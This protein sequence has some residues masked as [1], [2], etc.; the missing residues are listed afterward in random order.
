[1]N[2]LIFEHNDGMLDSRFSKGTIEEISL[3]QN[4]D[5]RYEDDGN[6]YVVGFDKKDG[7]KIM[8]S[9]YESLLTRV[10]GRDIDK[11][12]ISQMFKENCELTSIED[13]NY[14]V[15]NR[16]TVSSGKVYSTGR[17]I[18]IRDRYIRDDRRFREHNFFG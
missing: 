15:V 13:V 2:E 11:K 18:D 16:E 5:V 10:Y 8:F 3:D 7:I 1:M 6:F 4:V 14:M 12:F 9:V 17:G